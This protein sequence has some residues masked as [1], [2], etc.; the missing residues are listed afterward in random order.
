MCVACG[1]GLCVGSF[2]TPQPFLMFILFSCMLF[3]VRFNGETKDINGGGKLYL[4]EKTMKREIEGCVTS[5]LV[6]WFCLDFLDLM[7][8]VGSNLI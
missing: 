1:G 2:Y 7:K 3:L 8:I 4:C 5:F 6:G